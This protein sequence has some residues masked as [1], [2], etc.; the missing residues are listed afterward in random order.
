[1]NGFFRSFKYAFEGIAAVFKSGRNFR[2]MCFCGLLSITAAIPILKTPTEWMVL[3]S[4]VGMTLCAEA[5]NCSIERLCDRVTKRREEYIKYVKDAA[6]AAV[7]ILSISDLIIGIL[8]FCIDCKFL[9]IFDYC[10]NHLWY[11]VVIAALIIIAF[12]TVPQK[13]KD[14]K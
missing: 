13:H 6:A 14:K 5:F 10:R 2:F 8:L 1:M 4:A 7:L 9:K 3:I 11:P 12:I